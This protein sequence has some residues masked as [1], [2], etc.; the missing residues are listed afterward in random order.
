MAYKIRRRKI[1]PDKV[2]SELMKYRSFRESTPRTREEKL[3]K[4]IY[5]REYKE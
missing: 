2:Y 3:K 5:Y 1:N 4:A